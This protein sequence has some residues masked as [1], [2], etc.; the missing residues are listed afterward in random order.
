MATALD[1]GWAYKIPISNNLP[2]SPFQITSEP[3]QYKKRK[4]IWSKQAP[5]HYIELSELEENF[6][7]WMEVVEKD[8]IAII[9]DGEPKFCMVPEFIYAQMTAYTSLND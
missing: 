8:V 9:K 4:L 6:D 7:Y 2:N 3:S 1:F 5:K